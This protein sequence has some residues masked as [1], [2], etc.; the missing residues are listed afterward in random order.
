[1]A[2]YEVRNIL[3]YTKED[4][5]A[6]EMADGNIRVGITDYAQKMLKEIVFV[7][8]PQVGDAVKAMEPLGSIESVKAEVDVICPVSGTVAAINESLLDDP[9]ILNSDPYEAGWLIDVDP[10]DAAGDMAKLLSAEEYRA[11]LAEKAQ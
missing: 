1:M 10:S 7:N 2:D 3:S 11:L 5:W 6:R 9:S 4:T 8:L